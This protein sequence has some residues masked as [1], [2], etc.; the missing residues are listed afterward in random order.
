MSFSPS[1]LLILPTCLVLSSGLTIPEENFV[2]TGFSH[3]IG[4][5]PATFARDIESP[6]SISNPHFQHN[7]AR[8]LHTNDYPSQGIY[9]QGAG[10]YPSAGYGQTNRNVEQVRD[11]Q[12]TFN[13]H[14]TH[15]SRNVGVVQ[16]TS[17][18][19]GYDRPRYYSRK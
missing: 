16:Q 14:S 1:I 17:N 9:S 18:G 4:E 6:N 19:F 13:S 3:Q 11:E 5:F 8:R 10:G 15:Q 7:T 12:H 2:P